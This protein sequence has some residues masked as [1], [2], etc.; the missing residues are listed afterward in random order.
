MKKLFTKQKF[1]ATKSR[2]I[3]PLECEQCKK[4]FYRKKHRIQDAI[5]KKAKLNK[6]MYRFCS[7]SCATLNKIQESTIIT[8]CKN[9]GIEITKKRHELKNK[10]NSFCC[11]SC[12]TVYNNK[13]RK[14]I[15]TKER[16]KALSIKMKNKKPWNFGSGKQP[17]IIKLICKNC[18]TEFEVTSGKKN[19]KF[20]SIKCFHEKIPTGGF[21]KN[22][23]IKHRSFYRG[24]QM[25]SGA[26]LKFAKLM[27]SFS[28][29]WIKNTKTY[30]PYYFKEKQRKYYPDFFL[31]EYGLWIEIKGRLYIEPCTDNK[32]KSVF[33][34]GSKI[35]YFD[36]KFIKDKNAGQIMEAINDSKNLS[37]IVKYGI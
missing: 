35:L 5:T 4:V 25:D 28:I 32:L 11:G 26:E 1:V 23:T 17:K 24:F 2:D 12:R 15:W 14:S 30:F 31:E 19:Q 6:T 3:L 13:H 7:K 34:A 10:R 33:Y 20:C 18:G 27:D 21:R 16:K 36:S 9:C 8:F 37:S 22:S 29:K